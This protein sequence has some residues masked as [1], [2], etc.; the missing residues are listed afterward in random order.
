M[1]RIRPTLPI[2]FSGEVP[3]DKSISH[4]ALILSALASGVSVIDG[5]LHSA[6]TD[7]T[8]KCLVALGADLHQ[9]PGGQ[10]RVN[11]MSGR[12]S[13]PDQPL[14]A[15]NSGTTAR[16]LLGVLAAGGVQAA[17]DGDASLRQRPMLRVVEP[18]RAM[19]AQID[20]L[21]SGWRLPLK[22]RPAALHGANLRV[23]VASAQVKSALLLAALGAAG[24]TEVLLPQP[25]RDHT[26][27]MLAHF[28][29][30]VSQQI[31]TDGREL[32]ALAGPQTL[33]AAGLITVPGD[34]STAAFLWAA[35]AVTD[36]RAEVSGVCLNARRI[37]FLRLLAEMG[38]EVQIT[39]D[40][41]GP[42]PVGRVVV[43]GRPTRPGQVSGPQVA[44]LI[45]ELPLAACVMAVAPGLSRVEG[46]E[47]LRVKESD[48]IASM[49]QGLSALGVACT[50]TPSGWRIEGGRKIGHA[51]LDSHGDHR[52]AMALAVAAM[53][54]S[55]ES[56]LSG[57]RVWE[58]SYPTFV[59]QMR[60]AG[61]QLE[62]V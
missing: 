46:A 8:W 49:G 33:S 28:G 20:E 30:K 21:A 19:G 55:A 27:R 44:D 31:D 5:L 9:D 6:D 58:I 41:E 50:E 38:V 23:G 32:V 10:V 11:G 43:A 15:A 3:G 35:A 45:D 52:V 1:I 16:L 7:A 34:P 25:S 39:V 37:G 24:H 40:Q 42:E 47:E 56:T 48:R 61:G 51:Q 14:Q 60:L 2:E 4:R 53:A 18:L 57:D 29:V 54:G 62:R 36:G 59:E 17:L 13:Q 22:L 26:E 12:L